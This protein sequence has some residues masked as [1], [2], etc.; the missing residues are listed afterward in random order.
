MSHSSAASR[1]LLGLKLP[2]KS[3]EKN[4]RDPAG[5]FR[6]GC[7]NRSPPLYNPTANVAQRH[8][9]QIIPLRDVIVFLAVAAAFWLLYLLGDIFLPVFIALILADV[10][11]PFVTLLER[12][13]SC[14]R[15]LVAG[16]IVL[17]AVGVFFGFFAWL[18]PVLYDQ[19]NR[20]TEKLPD[21]LRALATS[22]GIDLGDFVAQLEKSIQN[23]ESAPHNLVSQIFRTTGNAVGIVTTVFGMA[24]TMLFS[25]AVVL[26]LFF[27]FAW[28][29]NTAVATVRTYLP[30][31][32]KEQIVALAERMD[33]VIG[34]F[35]RGR[36]LIALLVGGLLSAGWF[37]ADVPYWFFLG[38]VTGVLNIVPYL[39]IVTWP[40]AVLLKYVDSLTAGAGSHVDLLTVVIWPSVVYVAIQF[41]DGWILTPWIQ[42]GQTNMSAATVVI[43]VFI[44]GAIGGIWG[45]LFAIPAA[46]CIKILIE[47]LLLPRIQKWVATH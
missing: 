47:E 11:N 45:L 23:F 25:F 34:D 44:G 10:F 2:A 39:S 26:I 18:A 42:S 35:F 41:L 9:W 14:P 3:T 20:L 31:S 15:P 17:V 40:I 38:M 5:S 29:F 46:A 6:H 13:W 4:D 12:R 43:V 33:R 24:A 22:Y 8:V 16:A 32:R 7:D 21:Y 27:V 1:V 30:R 36:V 19:F 28:H 37:L